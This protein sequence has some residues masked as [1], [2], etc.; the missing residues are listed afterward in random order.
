MTATA[1]RTGGSSGAGRWRLPVASLRFKK[2]AT[3]GLWLGG[4]AFAVF[5]LLG[6]PAGDAQGIAW[7]TPVV[8]STPEDGMLLT[9][10][11]G[12]HDQVTAE[13]VIAQLDP[14]ELLLR[15]DILQAE[16]EALG[17]N[18]STEALVRLR[19][20]EGDR[21]EARLEQARLRASV[22]EAE[23]QLVA[24]Q[25]E[26]ARVEVLAERGLTAPAR[27]EDLRK[28]VEVIQARL[29]AERQRL[30]LASDVVDT[31]TSR[32]AVPDGPNEWLIVAAERRLEEIARRLGQLDLV[33]PREGQVTQIMSAPGEWVESGQP[34]ARISPL[35]TRE[36]H[37]WTDLRTAQTSDPGS[38][39]VVR[40]SSG[41]RLAGTVVSIAAESLPLPEELWYRSDIREWGYLVRIELEAAE[42]SPGE[43]VRVSLR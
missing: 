15:R 6:R 32:A 10:S 33:S 31:A 25:T 41:E 1:S 3:V 40:R 9:F 12:L 4:V 11:I 13:Q 37:V 39:A 28:E 18:E 42:L 8:V 20:Y 29:Q 14:A 24:G 2:L 22:A 23:A 21:E 38:A 35:T 36:V 17:T 30:R 19:R 16:L 34:I 7:A 27:A 26:L 5:L 43:R